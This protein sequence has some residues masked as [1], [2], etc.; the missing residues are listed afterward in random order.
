MQKSYFFCHAV[1]HRL[2]QYFIRPLL[3]AVQYSQDAHGVA[4]DAIGRD[5]RCSAYNQFASA[6]NASQAASLG[7]CKSCLTCARI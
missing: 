5:I 4:R 6:L 1:Q 2:I 7:Y 3:S